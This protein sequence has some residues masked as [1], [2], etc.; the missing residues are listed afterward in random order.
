VAVGW[1]S[2][3]L[4]RLVKGDTFVT[5]QL[6]DTIIAFMMLALFLGLGVYVVSYT[7]R[8]VLSWVFAMFCGCWAVYYVT[9]LILFSPQPITWVSIFWLRLRLA[10]L[11][12]IMPALF[13][14]SSYYFPPAIRGIRRV[15]MVLLYM[16]SAWLAVLAVGSPSIVAA[17]VL[18][19]NSMISYQPGELVPLYNFTMMVV[20][21]FSLN[22]LLLGVRYAQRPV[23]KRQLVRILIPTFAGLLVVIILNFVTIRFP[24]QFLHPVADALVVLMVFGYA[25]AITQHGA[26]VELPLPRRDFAYLALIVSLTVA[27]LWLAYLLD[28]RLVNDF[29]VPLPLVTAIMVVVISTLLFA[30]SGQVLPVL[31]R[32][33]FRKQHAQRL[34]ISQLSR[35]L[36]EGTSLARTLI[37]IL[38][39][40][41]RPLG[42]SGGYV[43]IRQPDQG[44]TD[45]L[46]FQVFVARGEIA[47]QEGAS[48]SVP[49]PLPEGPILRPDRHGPDDEL[50]SALA[51]LAEASLVYPLLYGDQI[52]GLLVLGEKQRTASYSTEEIALCSELASQLAV[53]MTM[54]RLRETQAQLL[55]ETRTKTSEIRHLQEQLEA[56]TRRVLER[57]D[58]EDSFQPTAPAELEIRLFGPL[59]VYRKGQLIPDE[60]WGSEKAKALLAFLLWRGPGGA[61]RDQIT[62]ALW[63]NR[64]LE[65]A[66][67][68]FHVTLYNLRRALE[69]GLRRGK[70][71]QY[72]L[73]SANRY[74]FAFDAPHRLDMT[75]V[76]SW[77]EQADR[78]ERSGDLDRAR[79]LRRRGLN[80][81]NGDFMADVDFARNSTLEAERE[82]WRRLLTSTRQKLADT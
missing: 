43:A 77:L 69:P 60:S 33:F 56:G 3:A 62:E 12:L 23:V 32:T 26:F 72:V 6:W 22:G 64:D 1:L 63:P 13:H 42:V 8:R 48:F 74:R 78:L 70:G 17:A 82:W 37:E 11:V 49:A 5:P 24:D 79:E 47:R 81:A 14:F 15:T 29:L 27:S 34:S 50:V 31:E 65:S 21:L 68:V 67:N 10:S 16:I 58:A 7:P 55:L 80:R 73:Y 44:V 2:E 38:D 59:L 76:K 53:A 20:Y 75:E 40:L 28:R 18:L 57:L 39:L 41:Q 36:S 46:M 52:T 30:S 25:W 4:A 45:T 19:P 54:T 71:S 61:T 35:G 9:R 66:A 51:T